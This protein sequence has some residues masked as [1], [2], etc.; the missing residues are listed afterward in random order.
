MDYLEGKIEQFQ[1]KLP[2]FEKE[3]Q[4]LERQIEISN[5]KLK[6]I[7]DQ[8][9]RDAK[10]FTK[11]ITALKQR[12]IAEHEHIQMLENKIKQDTDVFTNKINDLSYSIELRQIDTNLN[13]S[14]KIK[15]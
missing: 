5:E 12:L 14:S 9:E 10:Y 8:K 11:Q 6:L 15:G 13:Y 1:T 2:S 7:K 4:K 3:T